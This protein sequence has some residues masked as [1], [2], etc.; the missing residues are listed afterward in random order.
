MEYGAAW[1]VARL[2]EDDYLN[3][4]IC[5]ELHGDI[6]YYYAVYPDRIDIYEPRDLEAW[7]DDKGY[8]FEHLKPLDSVKIS[9]GVPEKYKQ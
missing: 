9:K 1:L 7:L 8:G 2:K 3:I 5:K 4:G 6:E